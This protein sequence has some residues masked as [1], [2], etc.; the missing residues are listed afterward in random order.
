MKNTVK[1]V[2]S[3]T[4]MDLFTRSVENEQAKVIPHVI[5]DSEMALKYDSK[6]IVTLRFPRLEHYFEDKRYC[7][8]YMLGW[9]DGHDIRWSVRVIEDD[10]GV[11]WLPT[12]Y[13]SF[14]PYVRGAFKRQDIETTH[15]QLANGAQELVLPQDMDIDSLIRAIVVVNETLYALD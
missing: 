12:K 6:V 3:A 5:T 4:L 14:V 15:I 1:A 7:T 9:L 11:Q 13:R 8:L 10:N 2:I